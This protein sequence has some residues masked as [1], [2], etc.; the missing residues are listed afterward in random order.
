MIMGEF[1]SP[2]KT[3]GPAKPKITYFLVLYRVFRLCSRCLY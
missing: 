3:V 2:K 1:N